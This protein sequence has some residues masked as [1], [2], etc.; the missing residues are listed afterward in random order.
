MCSIEEDGLTEE[1]FRDY[2]SVSLELFN[3]LTKEAK[4]LEDII[5][6]NMKEICND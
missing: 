2:L 6:A 4:K 5:N 3:N 1:E